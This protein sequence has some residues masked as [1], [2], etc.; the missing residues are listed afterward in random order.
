MVFTGDPTAE[1]RLTHS[2]R[3]LIQA[4]G[5]VGGHPLAARR[6]PTKRHGMHYQ[7]EEMER[8]GLRLDAFA[9]V[10]NDRLRGYG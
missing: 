9:R 4:A 1:Y 3:A 8:R 6:P 7:L 10:L 5:K 2:L